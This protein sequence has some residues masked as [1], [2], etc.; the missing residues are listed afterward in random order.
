MG[1][2]ARVVLVLAQVVVSILGIFFGASV[3]PDLV[4]AG[5]DTV[6]VRLPAH[7]VFREVLRLAGRPLAAPR[8]GLALLA[9]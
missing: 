7:P 2:I 1:K 9:V 8:A 4:T 3:L 6:A 5:T